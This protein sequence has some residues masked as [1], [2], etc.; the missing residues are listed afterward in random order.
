MTLITING[1]STNSTS[2][3][4]DV[5]AVTDLDSL[6]DVDIINSLA[7]NDVLQYNAS[8][9][10][11]EN[12]SDVTTNT[13]LAK[14]QVGFGY[15]GGGPLAGD[16]QGSFSAYTPDAQTNMLLHKTYIPIAS[17]A[18]NPTLYNVTQMA[19]T[20]GDTFV[21]MH[22]WRH[23]GAGGQAGKDRF[24]VIHLSDDG[25]TGSKM[26]S[27]QQNNGIFLSRTDVGTNTEWSIQG[28]S[29]NHFLETNMEADLNVNGNTTIGT[30][31]LQ[32]DA[33][34]FNSIID[35]VTMPVTDQ[36]HNHF[37]GTMDYGSNS[38]PDGAKNSITFTV[39]DNTN[40]DRI[41]ARFA[42]QY[43]TTDNNKMEI[44]TSDNNGNFTTN[45]FSNTQFEVGTPIKLF[46]ASA[47]PANPENGWVYY[48]TT[49][50]KMRLYAGGAWTDVN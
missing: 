2:T 16:P 11:W 45:S 13:L 28:G 38:V 34:A 15:Y 40:G 39:K 4:E 21:G 24:E 5:Q 35:T 33:A 27:M 49:T 41:V 37:R 17:N 8:T 14:T 32:T 48:N 20:D 7:T 47:D 19:G 30:L 25:T 44:E 42:S 23:M 9:L 1:A 29:I 46:N 50:D 43:N 26:L 31:Q 3:A 22:G 10:Q 36:L 12:T 6:H 18:G